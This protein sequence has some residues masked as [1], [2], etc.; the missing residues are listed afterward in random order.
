MPTTLPLHFV[1]FISYNN[2]YEDIIP[3]LHK[4]ELRLGQAKWAGVKQL[5]RCRAGIRRL[6]YPRGIQAS[7]C[8]FWAAK[9]SPEN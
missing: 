4:R 7:V 9:L 5:V 8:S 3:V 2:P 6:G 1:L